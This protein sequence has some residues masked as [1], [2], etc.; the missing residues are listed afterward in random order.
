[1]D[2]IITA[3]PSW[4]TTLAPRILLGLWHPM[5]LT[6]AKDRLPYCRRSHIGQSTLIARKYFWNDC[7]A[8][9]MDFGAL[10]TADGQK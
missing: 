4:E 9:S 1:M 7:E 8:F 5:F 3:Q 6:Y 2:A 10:T